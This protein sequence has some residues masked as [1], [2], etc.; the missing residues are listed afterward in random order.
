MNFRTICCQSL[1]WLIV[2]F[3]VGGS[4]AVA[5]SARDTKSL[6][7]RLTLGQKSSQGWGR[8]G[9]ARTWRRF[10]GWFKRRLSAKK[11][12]YPFKTY[13]KPQC[14]KHHLLGDLYSCRMHGIGWRPKEVQCPPRE[15][16]GDDEY[17]QFLSVI[18]KKKYRFGCENKQLPICLSKLHLQ[19][20]H[21][22]LQ[23]SIVKCARSKHDCTTVLA[24]CGC[25]DGYKR[26]PA[27]VKYG[28]DGVCKTKKHTRPMAMQYVCLQNGRGFTVD[29]KKVTINQKEYGKAMKRALTPSH[30]GQILG[31][32]KHD[33]KA[34]TF[35][36]RP[37]SELQHNIG[38]ISKAYHTI[39]K[40]VKKHPKVTDTLIAAGAL[41]TVI[42]LED[43]YHKANGKG[44]L[45]ELNRKDPGV[46][47]DIYIALHRL[48]G[49]FYGVFHPK[50]K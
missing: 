23:T 33:R 44:S 8:L 30:I 2:L 13:I 47:E 19:M 5:T 20:V 24:A 26:T 6:R 12:H 32:N 43:D 50:K 40:T 48:A 49:D 9:M 28:A 17:Q 22:S 38:W 34:I 27:V 4:E 16:N 7:T 35:S 42:A 1:V 29:R 21:A 37:L 3:S 46:G 36:S 14:C 15:W 25:P 41:F 18:D 10:R 31:H 45:L 11:K 39:V